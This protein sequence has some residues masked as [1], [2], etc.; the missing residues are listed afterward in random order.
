MLQC[1][2][3]L[4]SEVTGEIVNNQSSKNSQFDVEGLNLKGVNLNEFLRV[5]ALA[6]YDVTKMTRCSLVQLKQLADRCNITYPAKCSKDFLV[7]YCKR[8]VQF[9]QRR[10]SNTHQYFAKQKYTAGW[11]DMWCQ[12]G[13]KL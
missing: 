11:Q 8:V 1:P 10:E 12:H 13:V 2:P 4:A 9:I 3:I 6:D 7:E 5:M